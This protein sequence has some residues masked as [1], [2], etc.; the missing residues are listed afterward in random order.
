MS[1]IAN[2][3]DSDALHELILKELISDAE[4]T[5]D[6][7]VTRFAG[8]H[9]VGLLDMQDDFDLLN[10]LNRVIRFYGGSDIVLPSISR[11]KERL[12]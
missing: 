10:A 3:L 4:G 6:T 5:V 8:G 7:I 12:A 9:P 2:A 11:L 1:T